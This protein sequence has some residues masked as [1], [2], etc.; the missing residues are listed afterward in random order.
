MFF[1]QSDQTYNQRHFK[2]TFAYCDETVNNQL[3]SME[4]VHFEVYNTRR[5][6]HPLTNIKS[7]MGWDQFGCEIRKKSIHA[8]YFP[9]LYDDSLPA[10]KNSDCITKAW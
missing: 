1:Q 10:F 9:V 4:M 5:R 2:T 6:T 3:F 8:V 7:Q